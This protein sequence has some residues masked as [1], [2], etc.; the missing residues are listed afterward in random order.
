MGIDGPSAS[1]KSSTAGAVAQALGF[2]H[3]DSGALYRGL[4]FLALR[5]GLPAP[6]DEAAILEA[7][8]AA[9]LELRP[10]PGAFEVLLASSDEVLAERLRTVDVTRRVSEVAAMPAIRDWVN[11]RLRGAAVAGEAVVVDGRDIG[12][13]VFPAAQL[14]VFLTA[15]PA[16]RARRRL[17]QRGDE[18]DPAWLQAET[19]ALAARDLAD[20]N[21][22]VAPLLQAADSVLLDTSHMGF[23]QQVDRIVEL[24]RERG[25][26]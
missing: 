24:A 17:L 18:V 15:T 20:S 19:E 16:A 13:V 10:V 1:G 14:K 22:A 26:A 6:Y 23:D 9:G 25:L 4:T 2:R 21:R 7:A 3:L 11:D 5:A 8:E 12:S